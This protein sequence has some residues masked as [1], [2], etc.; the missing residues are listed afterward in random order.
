MKPVI[1][2]ALAIC[3]NTSALKISGKV[4]NYDNT[5]KSGIVVELSGINQTAITDLNGAWMLSDGNISVKASAKSIYKS[6][7]HLSVNDGRLN[8]FI[9]GHAINGSVQNYNKPLPNGAARLS[10]L[11]NTP[12]TIIYKWNG[13]V[14]LRDTIRNDQSGI[15]RYFDTTWNSAIIYGWINDVRD[16]N[17]YR[18]TSIGNQIWMAQNLNF[19]VDSSWCYIDSNANCSTYGRLYQWASLFKLNDSCNTHICSAL[20]SKPFDQGICPNGWHI[21][22]DSEW[23]SLIS[24][25]GGDSARFRLTVAQ[26]DNHSDLGWHLDPGTDMFGFRIL[27]AGQRVIANPA[28]Y[29]P[30]TYSGHWLSAYFWTSSESTKTYANSR[31]LLYGLPAIYPSIG[32]KYTGYQVRCI[33]N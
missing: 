28:T 8:L 16:G 3:T 31:Y 6:S 4:L 26:Q 29:T 18:T 5:P 25:V 17:I 13:K 23:S 30:V 21:S 27:P 9:N 32:D 20:I 14:I 15:I 33:K 22:T 2:T 1:L 24:F 11:N 19:K 7:T 12:D 10:G